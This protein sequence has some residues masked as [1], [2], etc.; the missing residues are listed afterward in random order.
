[1]ALIG[2]YHSFTKEHKGLIKLCIKNART[3]GN[4]SNLK[5]TEGNTLVKKL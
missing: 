4:F 1:M 2:G 5:K 3:N